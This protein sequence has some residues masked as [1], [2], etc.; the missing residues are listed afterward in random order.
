M[1]ASRTALNSSFLCGLALWLLQSC[2]GYDSQSEFQDLPEAG[3]PRSTPVRFSIR[4]K[5]TI[6]PHSFR[7]ALRHDQTYPFSNIFLITTLSHP[8]G[9]VIT[10]T[11]SYDLAA[12]DGQWLGS[13]NGMITH[14]LPFKESLR[15]TTAK[16]YEL[17]VY[18]AVR[19]LGAAEGMAFLPGV[20][21]VGYVLE[22]QPYNPK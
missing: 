4:P 16:P 13:G 22:K 18:Q 17:S 9:S 6:A 12:A 1:S 3:W 20:L 14:E 8:D 2:S 15:F 21:S 19:S 10:D 7:L 5:D 11:L